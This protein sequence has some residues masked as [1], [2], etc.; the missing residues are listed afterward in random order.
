MRNLLALCLLGL[1]VSAEAQEAPG[2]FVLEAGIS[3]GNSN[4]C[5]GHYVGVEGRIAGPVSAY[6]MV[7]TYRCVNLAGSASRLGASVRLGRSGW[8]VRPALRGGLEYD[9]GEVSHNVG[10]SLTLG[11][12]YGARFIVN[13]GAV[14]GAGAIVLLQLGGYISF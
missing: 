14:A 10:G 5:P 4:A 1:P 11:R 12:R 8:L 6:G 2:R 3:G 7:E 9:G 13:R